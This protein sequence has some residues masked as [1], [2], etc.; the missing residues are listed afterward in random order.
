MQI[1]SLMDR[2][3]NSSQN[4]QLILKVIKLT[5]RFHMKCDG[6]TYQ[7]IWNDNFQG[8]ILKALSNWQ[9]VKI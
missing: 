7:S 8:K 1:K 3:G 2:M 5:M 9:C 4:T 6:M